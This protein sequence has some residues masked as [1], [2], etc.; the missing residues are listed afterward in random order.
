MSAAPTPQGAQLP[1]RA[2]YNALE[3]GLYAMPRWFMIPLSLELG[4]GWRGVRDDKNRQVNLAQGTNDVGHGTLWLA[5]YAI[6]TADVDAFVAELRATPLMT[7]EDA[8]PAEVAGLPAQQFD[9][10]AEPNPTESGNDR[11]E[12]GTVDILA[13]HLLHSPG[14]TDFDWYT[15][16]VE[17][18]L[19]F[20]FVEVGDYTLVIY[21]EAPPD[22]FDAFTTDL[23]ASVLASIL[24]Y[25]RS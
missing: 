22:E 15:E 9:A 20:M 21:L 4:E 1:I 16:S 24:V 8:V 25:P 5:P 10:Q 12:P 13:M 17:A 14:I 7:F 2:G 19:R 23:A 11:R 18:R 6:S 3:P